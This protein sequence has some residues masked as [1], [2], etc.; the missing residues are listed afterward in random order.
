MLR[1]TTGTGIPCTYRHE[2]AMHAYTA[3]LGYT[4][5]VIKT[6]CCFTAFSTTV[7]TG[8][9]CDLKVDQTQLSFALLNTTLTLQSTSVVNSLIE[10]CCD[11][12]RKPR[13]TDFEKVVNFG[14]N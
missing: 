4:V 8:L 9:K 7:G 3:Q 13:Q 6:R 10:R 5:R 11:E 1:R 2:V 12:E 14:I